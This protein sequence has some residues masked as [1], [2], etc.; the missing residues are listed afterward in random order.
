MNYPNEFKVD[1]H[2]KLIEN[3][4][5]S[6][7]LN[8]IEKEVSLMDLIKEKASKI[9]ESRFEMNR[10]CLGEKYYNVLK[11]EKT[12]V[13]EKK[14]FANFMKYGRRMARV[15]NSGFIGKSTLKLFATK[16]TSSLAKPEVSKTLSPALK[17][18]SNN[19]H[20]PFKH[21]SAIHI[22]QN[23]KRLAFKNIDIKSAIFS[24]SSD[25]ESNL[26]FS[27]SSRADHIVNNALP[28]ILSPKRTKDQ[29]SR[30]MFVS[31]SFAIIN[32]KIIDYESFNPQ[33]QFPLSSS[34]I[35]KDSKDHEMDIDQVISEK[36]EN[37]RDILNESIISNPKPKNGKIF[38]MLKK[39]NK[40]LIRSSFMTKRNQQQL[41]ELLL[42]YFISDIEKRRPD[43][44]QHFKNKE[45]LFRDRL[46]K[47]SYLDYSKLPKVQRLFH[48][49]VLKEV[50]LK[51]IENINQ[52]ELNEKILKYETEQFNQQTKKV[53]K[54]LPIQEVEELKIYSYD[55]ERDFLNYKKK[56]ENALN[57]AVFLISPE[58]ALKYG[59]D[60]AK[61]LEFDY[62]EDSEF[63]ELVSSNKKTLVKCNSLVSIGIKSKALNDFKS[64]EH[65]P[66]NFFINNLPF[67]NGESSNDLVTYLLNKLR[68]EKEILKGNLKGF[69]NKN[70]N[71]QPKFARYNDYEVN[72]IKMKEIYKKDVKESF[73]A[74]LPNVSKLLYTSSRDKIRES[75]GKSMMP[76]EFMKLKQTKNVDLKFHRLKKLELELSQIPV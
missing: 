71:F 59:L 35:Q 20:K 55:Q 7:M 66:T 73:K 13:A 17:V 69:S 63:R 51:C 56:K 27:S 22:R 57:N 16:Q 36:S 15:G 54:S 52:Q 21:G 42:D 60:L 8:Q 30:N 11:K 25:D 19:D 38:E 47:D 32:N 1:N 70:Y 45:K 76:D 29:A 65:R 74:H 14:L 53:I 40:G 41:N 3:G 28:R 72:S 67:I 49:E 23:K 10:I 9:E 34:V 58:K 68:L 6:T 5:F 62:S 37:E 26:L 4:V 24:D 31:P 50:F 43:I 12:A 48:S 33:A 39:S 61:K 18:N 75:I 44:E 64:Q 46:K 2:R